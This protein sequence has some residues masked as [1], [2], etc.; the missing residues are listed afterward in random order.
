MKNINESNLKKNAELIDFISS[1]G[2]FYRESLV[3]KRMGVWV[4]LK[5]EIDTKLK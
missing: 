5:F 2:A 4:D 3:I 1:R